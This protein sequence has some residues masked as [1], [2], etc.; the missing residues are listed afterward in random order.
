MSKQSRMLP[1]NCYISFVSPGLQKRQKLMLPVSSSLMSWTASAERGSSLP[2]ILIPDKQLTS[3]WQKWTGQ[4]S[5]FDI[6]K[7][8]KS[9]QNFAV[10]VMFL[11]FTGLNQMKV[12][13]LLVLQTLQRLWIS[14]FTFQIHIFIFYLYAL[15]LY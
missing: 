2:C 9:E 6:L 4:F 7:R 12:S 5:D 10:L 13:L 11:C 3:C 14:M 15:F 8:K 1:N